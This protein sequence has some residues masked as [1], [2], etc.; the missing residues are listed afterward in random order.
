MFGGRGAA[1]KALERGPR[2]IVY[3]VAMAATGTED[4][5]P[6]LRALRKFWHGDKFVGACCRKFTFCSTVKVFEK[7]IDLLVKVRDPRFLLWEECV[8]DSVKHCSFPY[9]VGL[10]AG[11]SGGCT[12]TLTFRTWSMSETSCGVCR[13]Q[14]DR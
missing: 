12:C 10:R 11:K 14:G 4:D 13:T 7:H 2:E 6:L 8:D 9:L 3:L 5:L 1:A